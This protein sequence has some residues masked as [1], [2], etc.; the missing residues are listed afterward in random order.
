L[1][2]TAQSLLKSRNGRACFKPLESARIA[3]MDT[4]KHLLKNDQDWAEAILE[5]DPVLKNSELLPRMLP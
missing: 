2:R 3:L 5:N 1:S 4:F